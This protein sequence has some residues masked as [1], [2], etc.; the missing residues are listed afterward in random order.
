MSCLNT[1]DSNLLRWWMLLLRNLFLLLDRILGIKIRASLIDLRLLFLSCLVRSDSSRLHCLHDKRQNN[2]L[3][4]HHI[5][6]SQKSVNN[7]SDSSSI[8][9]RRF[10]SWI[11][12]F[13]VLAMMLSFFWWIESMIVQLLSYFIAIGWLAF[14]AKGFYLFQCWV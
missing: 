4:R 9:F 7:I 13:I 3:F 10:S 11:L 2:D 12:C 1:S 14:G 5:F 6:T 8:G